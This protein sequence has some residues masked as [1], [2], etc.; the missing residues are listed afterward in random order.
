MVSTFG[1]KINTYWRFFVLDPR[2]YQIG[3]LSSLI[4]IGVMGFGV[5]MPWWHALSCIGSA[6]FT[7]FL[8]DRFVKNRFDI[9]SPLITSLS[10][11][12]LLRTGS[13]WL[14]LLAGALAIGS[15]Y[16]I[17][18]QGK[19]IFNPANFGI[20][21]VALLFGGAWVSPGQWGTAPLLILWLAGFG[22]LVTTKAK[23]WDLTVFFLATYA[24]LIFARTLWLGDP[25]AI[26]LHQLQNGAL[27]LFACFMIS[28]PKTTPNARKGRFLY[29]A[30][31][32]CTGFVLH[33]FFYQSAGFIIALILTAP[34]VPAFDV[35]FPAKAYHWPRPSSIIT[36]K[37]T[38]NDTLSKISA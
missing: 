22:I 32:A 3:I 16:L 18:C 9:R 5:V 21:S 26:P 37:E 11:T 28:D 35:F 25:F 19:H 30:L 36:K 15:K 29:A 4:V 13:I 12:L 17:R 24:A 10:L 38:T 6:V 14:S 31:V 34:L 8:G 2:H 7:Q 23:S 33:V 1:D 20:V 27:L